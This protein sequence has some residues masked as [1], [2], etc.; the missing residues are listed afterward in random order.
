MCLFV[1]MEK[2]NYSDFINIDDNYIDYIL[3]KKTIQTYTTLVEET[4][5][6]IIPIYRNKLKNVFCVNCNENGHI[7]KD[8][9]G[10]ITSFG[11]IA[12]KIVNDANEE[13]GDKN[14][15]LT[16]L[17]AERR[18]NFNYTKMI[19]P[20]IKFLMIQRKDTMG[21]IDFLRGKYKSNSDD[22][23]TFIDEMTHDEKYSLL[24]DTFE[25]NWRRL[26]KNHKSR[27]FLNEYEKAK[28]K[29]Y[30]LDNLQELIEKSKTNY[31]FQEFSFPKGRKN[32]KENNLSCAEREFY[33]ETGYKRNQ[34]EFLYNYPTIHED[35]V[36]TNGVRYRHVYYIVK[37]KKSTPPPFLDLNNIL[38]VGEVRNIG[39]F[40]FD[41][42]MNLIR[43]YDKAKK[44]VIRKIFSD[45]I[46]MNNKFFC[47]D[48]Y[49]FKSPL[50]KSF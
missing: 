16:R 35:F 39:W 42:C 43:P 28:L 18:L 9:K 36:G 2:L 7:I 44:G 20:K 23:Q 37:M 47:S 27:L 25:N 24:N 10:P 32:M 6:Y 11:I 33:E 41:E 46:N 50:K 5:K 14:E 15:Y 19:Y 40:S 38:Q 4:P 22:I 45:I 26:W 30:S 13:Y 21:Y 17:L 8:C 29:F 49:I 1:N 34:Y 31:N 12:F 3:K 48:K